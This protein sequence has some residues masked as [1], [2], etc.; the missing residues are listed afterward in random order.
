MSGQDKAKA[1]EARN[2]EK[3]RTTNGEEIKEI[4]ATEEVVTEEKPKRTQAVSISYTLKAFS[5]NIEKLSEA[6]MI[7]EEERLKAM[8]VKDAAVSKYIKDKF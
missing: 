8:Q 5:N 6:G 7:T 2:E 4:K 3:N 1:Q